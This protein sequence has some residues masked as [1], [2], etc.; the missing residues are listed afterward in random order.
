MKR[1]LALLCA[2]LAALALAACGTPAATPAPTAIATATPAPTATPTP[3]VA[4]PPAATAAATAT[5]AAAAISATDFLGATVTL[6][7]APQRIISLT[8][9]NTET[10]FALGL[11]SKVIGV[12]AV[13]NYPAEVA[14]IEKVGDFN[15]PDLEK[16]AGLKPDLV[17]AG[18][19]LQKETIE[20]LQALGLK[21]AAVEGTTYAE[22]F[23]SITMI[24]A[25]TGAVD[26]AKALV[27]DMHRKEQLVKDAIKDK[28]SGKLAY[29]C[30][31]YGQFGD[32]SAGP[33]SFPY[34][35]ISMCG[36]KNV[37]E[38]LPVPWP[39]MSLEGIVKAN[40][41]V[42]LLSSDLEGG[43]AAF[44]GSEGYKALTASKKNQVF[45]ITSDTCMRPGPR[46]VD[47]FR[48]FAQVLCG[49]TISFDK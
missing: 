23:D 26:Q 3:E 4:T 15:G 16:I 12:D 18:N 8:P 43:V 40:P 21:V 30:I 42:V 41:D 7:A 13:S 1:F 47:G 6:D 38:G 33:G 17:L 11:G 34:E 27:D 29:F 14:S 45:L 28:P 2:L 9:S 49:V 19:K 37:T 31:S 35:M 32:Y 20:K 46:I 10:L 48:E 44:T 22:A 36:A 5:P 25:L 39:Q 24:G